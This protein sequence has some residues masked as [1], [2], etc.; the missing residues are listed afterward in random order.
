MYSGA[1]HADGNICASGLVR[2]QVLVAVAIP[3]F[4]SITMLLL[5]L[6]WGPVLTWG[7]R[8]VHRRWQQ[9]KRAQQYKVAGSTGH[10]K[11]QKRD[12]ALQPVD[13]EAVASRTGVTEDDLN[14]NEG[15]TLSSD[16]LEA[17][18]GHDLALDHP[19]ADKCEPD[20]SE[21]VVNKSGREARRALPV[22]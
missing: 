20:E 7:T 9:Y 22:R 1:C 10:T 4:A 13:E 2:A 8:A 5:T 12:P 18:K 6:V 11:S 19:G 21:E 3:I 17:I 14:E 16:H 15:H